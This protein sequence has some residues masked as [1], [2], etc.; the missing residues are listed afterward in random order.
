[1]FALWPTVAAAAAAAAALL[2]RV[3]AF[4]ADITQHEGPGALG[5]QLPGPSVDY[6]SMVFVLS[7]VAPQK[8][9]QA[10][11]QRGCSAVWVGLVR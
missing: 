5:Q 4:V 3:T 11:A 1:M 8:M 2:G 9:R 7:A 6:C 10:S